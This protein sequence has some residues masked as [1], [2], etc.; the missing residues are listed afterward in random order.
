VTTTTYEDAATASLKAASEVLA[1]ANL[2]SDNFER[3]AL[4]AEF[5]QAAGLFMHLY[6]L[7]QSTLSYLRLRQ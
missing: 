4:L 7:L 2:I 6:Q 1:A 3:L 5:L